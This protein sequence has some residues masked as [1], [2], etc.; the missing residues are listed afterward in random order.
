MLRTTKN[1]LVLQSAD[2]YLIFRLDDDNA[3]AVVQTLT[4]RTGVAI[5]YPKPA[6]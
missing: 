5:T 6:K 1:W 3:R 4:G 2:A